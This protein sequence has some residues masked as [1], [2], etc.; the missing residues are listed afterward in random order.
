MSFAWS[1]LAPDDPARLVDGASIP[2]A[3]SAPAGKPWTE[4]RWGECAWPVGDPPRPE[5]QRSCCAPV[6]MGGSY[7]VAHAKAN[8]QPGTA[9]SRE[10]I[11]TIVDIARRCR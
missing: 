5:L 11:D 6:V 9:L 8:W 7:C 10:E 4:R 2:E 3:P 1:R